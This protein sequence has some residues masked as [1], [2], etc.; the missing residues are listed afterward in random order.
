MEDLADIAQWAQTVIGAATLVFI[1][2]GAVMALLPAF[3]EQAVPRRIK[4][5]ATLAFTAIVAPLVLP[6]YPDNL[7]QSQVVGMIPSE[8]IAGLSIGILFRLFVIALQIAGTIAGQSTSLSQIFGAGVGVEPQPT[9]ST[10]LVMAGLCLAVIAGLHVYVV[11]ALILSYEI[12]EPGRAVPS[13][14]L[15]EWG[16]SKIAASF[17]LGFTLAGPFVLISVVYNLGLGVINKAM[18]QLM[19]AFVGAPAI[20]FAGMVMLLIAA[21]FLLD[22]W[23]NAFEAGVDFER[24]AF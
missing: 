7:E 17:A 2:V 23:K 5:G 12:F 3:G 14:D 8:V 22:V 20:S 6:L 10:L 4:L 24:G 9:F 11:Q 19:V 21:P 18:P 15:Y 16:V 13:T 1:R